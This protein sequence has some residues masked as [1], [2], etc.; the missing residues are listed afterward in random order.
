MISD[1][2][3]DAV[4]QIR[5]YQRDMP[6]CYD[7]IR[8]R[9]DTVVAVMDDLRAELDTPP[10]ILPMTA[11]QMEC[12]YCGKTPNTGMRC[13]ICFESSAYGE[14]WTRYGAFEW[15]LCPRCSLAPRAA[16]A[17]AMCMAGLY[18]SAP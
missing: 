2:L 14:G 13:N 10:K 8:R 12:A 9:I 1:I 16:E 11:P 18:E 15:D 6:S 17:I 3:S 4:D 5:R 7:G